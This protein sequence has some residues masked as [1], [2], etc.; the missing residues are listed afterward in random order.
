LGTS[1][2]CELD[3]E[4]EKECFSIDGELVEKEGAFRFMYLINNG[5]A[6]FQGFEI[7]EVTKGETVVVS[8]A[9]GATGLLICHLLK[10]KGAKIVAICSS[11]KK[12]SLKNYTDHCIDY[13]DH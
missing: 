3:E 13:R 4:R 1:N 11:H 12:D 2:Y 8:T 5:L 6:S 7:L 9:A 10:K